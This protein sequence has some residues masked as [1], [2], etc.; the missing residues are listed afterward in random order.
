MKD[1]ADKANEERGVVFGQADADR[2]F[3]ELKGLQ[4]DLDDDPLAHGPKRLN[5]KVSNVRRMLAR[6][7]RLFLDVSQKLHRCKRALKVETLRLDLGKKNLL[8]NDPHTRAGRSIADRE[9]IMAGKLSTEIQA[10]HDLEMAEQDLGSVLLVIRAK[11]TDLRDAEG[12]LRDQIRICQE[13][14][15][16]GA[17]WG[18]KIPK[19]SD[20]VLP[21]VATPADLGDLNDL[22]SGIEGEIH[23]AAAKGNWTASPDDEDVAVVA[24]PVPEA[25]S[26][27]AEFDLGLDDGGADLDKA[28]PPTSDPKAS[29]SFLALDITAP[30]PPSQKKKKEVVPLD[31]NVLDDIL[32]SFEKP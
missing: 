7:E 31:D 23:V 17:R 11:R 27:A 2:I 12:R 8:A 14:I 18:S 5:Q 16:L 22:M 15:G 3:E 4:V 32:G 29:D 21:E 1:P 6:C 9:A 26:P 25:E 10:V 28:L 19:G 20:I 13:E 24:A 30:P